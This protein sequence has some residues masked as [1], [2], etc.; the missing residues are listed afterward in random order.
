MKRIAP[1][2]IAVIAFAAFGIFWIVSD[3]RAPQRIYDHYST[4]N[5]SADGL[6]LAAGYLRAHHKVALLTRP[7]ARV[8]VERDAVIFRISDEPAFFFDPAD[9]ESNKIG[10]PKPRIRALLNDAEEAFVRGGGRL[11]L[12]GAD[13]RLEPDNTDLKGAQKVF[14]IWPNL[15]DLELC[16]CDPIAFGKLRPRMHAIYSVGALTVVARER[17]G[18]GELFQLSA[19]ELLINQYLEKRS[20]LELLNALA[21]D[22]RPIYF[23]EVPHGIVSNDGALAL[24]KE[25][26]LGPFLLMLMAI[27]ALAFWRAGRRIGRPEDDYRDTRSDA[28]DLVHSLA[29]FYTPSTSSAAAIA[30]YHESLTRT[31]AMQS[32][33]R[34]D[35]LRKRIDELTGGFTPPRKWDDIDAATFRAQLDT[36]NEAFLKLRV[37]R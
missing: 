2:V 35:V 37:T 6:S 34:G 27:A 28:V 25:W 30:L 12:A 16:D 20:H 9:L 23:D 4:A 3:R 31:V 1:L 8:K 36:I 15:G 33:L 17:I 13:E 11:V 5:T 21:G 26:N 22:R 18:A 7:L 29:A 24:M 32:G 19:P 14:P 10:P